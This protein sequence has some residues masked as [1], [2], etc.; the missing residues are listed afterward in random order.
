MGLRVPFGTTTS[1]AVFGVGGSVSLAGVSSIGYESSVVPSARSSWS[2]LEGS[3]SDIAENVSACSSRE[4]E[5]DRPHQLR[6][7]VGAHVDAR[8]FISLPFNTEK[9]YVKS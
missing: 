3:V 9:K 7:V 4:S 8:G 6:S 2:G 5:S 1:S